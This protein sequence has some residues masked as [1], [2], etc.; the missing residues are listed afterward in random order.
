M[1]STKGRHE[2]IHVP[3]SPR[4]RLL[5]RGQF[6]TEAKQL[7]ESSEITSLL[8]SQRHGW[9]RQSLTFLNECPNLSELIISDDGVDDL[10]AVSGLDAL[11]RVVL[12]CPTARV[13][14]DFSK[15]PRL[16]DAR[17][18]WRACYGSLFACATLECLL[19]DGLAEHDLSTF[20]FP[21]LTRLHLL[22]SRRLNTL[23][24]ISRLSR[25][26]EAVILQCPK[27]VALED[28][29]GTSLESFSIEACMKVIDLH[30]IFGMNTLSS[31]VVERCADIRSIAGVSGLPLKRIRLVDVNIIDGNM[32]ELL[33]LAGA[34][35]FF[36]SR[37]HYTHKMVYSQE[38]RRFEMVAS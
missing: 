6:D 26:R 4:L 1:Q 7:L 28:L 32:C 12:E 18:D 10:A 35:I 14:P 36:T 8:L 11:E 38:L 16:R 30:R 22:R 24:G 2:V 13:G 9:Q 17:V 21:N 37:P 27:L 20:N 5:V 31:I 34:E 29:D 25:L 3:K 33:N 23:K 15:L 19:I